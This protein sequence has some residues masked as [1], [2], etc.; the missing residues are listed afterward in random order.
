LT[1]RSSEGFLFRLTLHLFDFFSGLP[2]QEIQI[3]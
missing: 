2:E 3:V 1:G